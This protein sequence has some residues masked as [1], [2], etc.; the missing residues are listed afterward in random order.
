ML[1]RKERIERSTFLLKPAIDK[2]K[3]KFD[4]IASNNKYKKSNCDLRQRNYYGVY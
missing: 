2:F 4:Y 3:R 1:F